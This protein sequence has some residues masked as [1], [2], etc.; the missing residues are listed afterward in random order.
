LL[1]R[2]WS[3]GLIVLG[4][5][6]V[7]GFLKRQMRP[8]SPLFTVSWSGIRFPPVTFKIDN[9]HDDENEGD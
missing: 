4:V 5:V 2:F 3:K 8:A 9:E 7:L 1:L 6:L